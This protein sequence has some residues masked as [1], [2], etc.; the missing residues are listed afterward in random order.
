MLDSGIRKDD[1]LTLVDHVNEFFMKEV[2]IAVVGFVSA[3]TEGALNLVTSP[4]WGGKLD[5][6]AVVLVEVQ[7]TASRM[8]HIVEGRK[9][10]SRATACDETPP[11]QLLKQFYITNYELTY[12]SW[13]RLGQV[14]S[15][16]FGCRGGR[17]FKGC[18]TL[19]GRSDGLGTW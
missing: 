12:V 7:Q 18:R 17:Q 19:D 3:P 4:W 8:E 13:H 10:A 9:I 11:P 16:L 2:H 15:S 1:P 5:R 6:C 14:N